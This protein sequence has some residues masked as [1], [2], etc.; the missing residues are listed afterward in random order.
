VAA[1]E[2]HKSTE[3]R[4]A[5]GRGLDSLLPSGPRVVTTPPPAVLPPP[6]LVAGRVGEMQ[7]RA[8]GDVVEQI[9]QNHE[10]SLLP[11]SVQ[12]ERIAQAIQ[13][14]PMPPHRLDRFEM[15]IDKK[16]RDLATTDMLRGL[17]VIQEERIH[18]MRQLEARTP[19]TLLPNG[20]KEIERG[21]RIA[22]AIA[23]GDENV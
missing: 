5:L 15:L 20:Y 2:E 16:L 6:A 10:L 18:E 17:F 22:V 8:E 23:V 12:A 7:A 13:L 4:R 11:E 19:G 3:K 9:Q 1:I 14:T 21:V